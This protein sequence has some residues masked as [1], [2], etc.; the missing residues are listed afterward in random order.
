MFLGVMALKLCNT[1]VSHKRED[2]TKANYLENK[3]LYF[4][5][6]KLRRH[7]SESIIPAY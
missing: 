4:V 7:R 6:L 5:I 1:I 2:L 3:F